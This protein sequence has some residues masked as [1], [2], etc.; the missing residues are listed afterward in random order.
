M[1][2]AFWALILGLSVLRAERD[3][4]TRQ[5]LDD[6]RP[7]VY[8]DVLMLDSSDTASPSQDLIALYAR[9]RKDRLEIRLD[10]L[11]L[12]PAPDYDLYLALDTHPGGT[13]ILPLATSNDLAW[14]TLLVIHSFGP[15]QA[16]DI[17]LEPR[18]DLIPRV[19]RDPDLDSV[20]ISLSGQALGHISSGLRIAVWLTAPE[21]SIPIDRFETTQL[22][23]QPPPR[24]P[25]M[26]A[27][28]HTF[29]AF[30]PAR[31]VRSWDGAH[32]GPFGERHG[33]RNLLE[34]SQY[35]SVPLFLLDL[36]TPTSLAYLDY[37]GVL[38]EVV[39]LNRAGLVILPDVI[40]IGVQAATSDVH[41]AIPERALAW[42]AAF[43]RRTAQTFG[44]RA[45]QML[46]T[47][48]VPAQPDSAHRIIL[49]HPAAAQSENNPSVAERAANPSE[50][51]RWG[52]RKLLQLPD[53]GPD[54]QATDLG[55]SLSLRQEMIRIATSGGVFGQVRGAEILVMGGD[56]SA[57]SWADPQAARRTLRYL[58]AHPWI[59]PL[60]AVD[61]LAMRPG[62]ARRPPGPAPISR[63]VV[64]N[65]EGTEDP[66][67]LTVQEINSRIVETLSAMPAGDM[68]DLIWQAYFALLDDHVPADARLAGLRT[69]YL[70][71]LGPLLE[72]ARWAAAPVPIS[73]CARDLDFDHD[74]ECVLASEQLFTVLDI[75]GGRLTHAF[76]RSDKGV[77][78][79]I[80]PSSQ[81]IIG[82]SDPA[83]WDITRG[84]AGDP[85]QYPGAFSDVE[86]MWALYEPSIFLRTLAFIAPDGSLEKTFRLTNTGMRVD[87]LQPMDDTLT[88]QIPLVIHPSS[89]F[90]PGWADEFQDTASASGVVLQIE[91]DQYVEVRSSGQIQ[92]NA[93]TASRPADRF[94]GGSES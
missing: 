78:Q 53:P 67:G 8:S 71:Q 7:W 31:A 5:L 43:S 36:K 26:L 22:T 39:N 42:G 92:I 12:N 75:R 86:R 84:P 19:V 2:L 37:L 17:T 16:L 65:L 40:P 90:H 24:V 81:F 57:S 66:S 6:I 50:L 48:R 27:F 30:T 83:E 15:P 1:F 54:L 82:L 28:W 45:S 46:Y 44:L 47:A 21:Q 93:F 59:L 63:S 23:G 79:W 41:F 69:G 34:A 68:A 9:E 38:E 87:Y 32:S 80:A 91:D 85:G 76:L 14:E 89:R 18:A 56:L 35:F 4:T 72:A 20:E 73:D 62:D 3:L 74:S 52:A 88:V 77:R 55:P 29:P 11:D 33:L 58:A 25:V 51:S 10:F 94:S 70:G 60:R 61:L 13:T 64:F 49:V